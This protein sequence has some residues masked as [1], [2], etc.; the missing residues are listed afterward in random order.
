MP[1][2]MSDTPM[3]TF[4]IEAEKKLN[5]SEIS[6]EA[7]INN[8]LLLNGTWKLEIKG[9]AFTE[10]ESN[11]KRENRGLKHSPVFEISCNLVA[12]NLKWFQYI[13]DTYNQKQTYRA[14]YP[15][16]YVQLKPWDN[17]KEQVI[18]LKSKKHRI[19]VSSSDEVTIKMRPVSK[20]YKFD[21]LACSATVM[22]SL[23]KE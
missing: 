2:K 14:Q 19:T 17:S 20:Q 4:T 21:D 3:T 8:T 13:M 6:W 12:N 18:F 7:K 9:V 5:D 22:L 1:F 16:E 15:I 10:M 11:I 23:F